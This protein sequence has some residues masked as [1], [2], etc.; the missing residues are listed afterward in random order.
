MG[1][2][3]DDN[4]NQAGGQTQI[5]QYVGCLTAFTMAG[6]TQVLTANSEVELAENE[7]SERLVARELLLQK[8]DPTPVQWNM[9]ARRQTPT[10]SQV[11]I[12]ITTTALI[13]KAVAKAYR[14][15]LTMDPVNI[16][17]NNG[18]VT[19]ACEDYYNDGYTY[20][21]RFKCI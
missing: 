2:E 1:I 19:F 21:N 3:V 5:Y 10:D 4:G 11:V 7:Y 16:T 14:Q 20:T 13:T 15:G 6:N 17:F 9:T 12:N 18:T 8:T